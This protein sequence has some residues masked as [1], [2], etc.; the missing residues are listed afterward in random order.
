MSVLQLKRVAP[1]ASYK[2]C[3]G[4][5]RAYPQRKEDKPWKII[6]KFS[7]HWMWPS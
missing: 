5:P 4:R 3:P 6:A 2:G 7:S 1:N